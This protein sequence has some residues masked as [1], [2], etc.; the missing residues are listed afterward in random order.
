MKRIAV[1]GIGA[2]TP[3]GLEVLRAPHGTAKLVAIGGIDSPER[4]R[5]AA[6]AGAD[7]VAVIRAAWSG[8]SLV[9][10]VTAVDAGRALRT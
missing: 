1:T 8:G 2:V 7:A 6:M 10:Y 9:P 5:D 4:A 3:L